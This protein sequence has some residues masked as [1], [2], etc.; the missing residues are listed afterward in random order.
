MAPGTHSVGPSGSF[1]EASSYLIA[2][3]FQTRVT[4][5]E[6]Q[7]NTLIVAGAYVLI[8]GILWCVINKSLVFLANRTVDVQAC[9]VF[10][11]NS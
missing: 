4:P 11:Q 9:T 3:D 5:N 10:E 2:R 6:T 8:I 7:R 1:A